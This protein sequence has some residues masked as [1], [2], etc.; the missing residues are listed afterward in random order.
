MPSFIRG[1]AYNI[2][3]NKIKFIF[4]ILFLMINDEKIN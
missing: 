2:S 4:N 3:F 1:Y